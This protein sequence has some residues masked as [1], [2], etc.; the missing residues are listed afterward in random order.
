LSAI[1]PLRPGALP[2]DALDTPAD[3]IAARFRWARERGHPGYVWP[4]VP[5][6][7][8]LACGRE[9]ERVA[10]ARLLDESAA[11]RLE[12]PSGASAE[13]VGIAAFSSGMGPLLGHWIESG[14]V[15]AA[16]EVADILALHLA[17]GR[18]RA[19]RQQAALRGAL[20]AMAGADVTATVVK[21]AH[22]AAYF[23]EA[24]AR[25]AADVD[26][27]IARPD[28]GAAEAALAAAG[29]TRGARQRRPYK[30][31]WVPPDSPRTLPS[32]DVAHADAPF[33]IELHDSLER[34]FFG[35]RRISFVSV[36]GSAAAPAIHPAAR[37]LA[38]PLL[39]AFLA[40]HASEELHQLQLLR[41][42]ELAMVVRTDVARAALGWN[43]L[44]AL[45]ELEGALRFTYPAFALTERLAP[46][47]VDP[48]FL[49]R[50]TAS[51]TPRMRRLIGALSPAGA[52]RPDRVSLEERFLW[53]DGPLETVRR[54]AYLLWPAHAARSLRP[55]RTVYA[56]RLYRVVRRRASLRASRNDGIWPD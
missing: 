39:T 36:S 30:C 25:T 40:T 46:G 32:L 16:P 33:A 34:V 51:A 49:A 29:F 35:V 12:V 22:T 31:D 55:L 28:I 24:G 18:R 19:E 9:I 56:E 53:A 2:M 38:Q 23:P 17:H 52:L 42:V 54:A 13:A 6:G 5:I 37:V 4:R 10:R 44:L 11:P 41:L 45:L 47:T 8:W 48:D 3:E 26:L 1:D 50:V 21:G 27:V 15:R 7:R 43:E 14:A 20:D